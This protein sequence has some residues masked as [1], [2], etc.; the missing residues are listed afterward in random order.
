MCIRDRHDIPH[1]N[2]THI[3]AQIME[4]RRIEFYCIDAARFCM[5]CHG[6]CE[7]SDT[8]KHVHHHLPRTELAHPDALIEVALGEHDA[9]GIELVE[10]AV[11]FMYGFGCGA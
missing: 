5:H 11:F 8:C 6:Y 3:L 10:A 2:Q 1:P 7:I 9:C 4:R